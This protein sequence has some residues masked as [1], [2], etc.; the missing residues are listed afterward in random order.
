MTGWEARA[1]DKQCRENFFGDRR[2]G[3]P[4]FIGEVSRMESVLSEAG[5]VECLPKPFLRRRRY[6]ERM[7]LR[8]CG[9][10][11]TLGSYLPHERELC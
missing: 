5:W 10:F 3:E 1:W 11:L 4:Y 8:K 6:V 9:L 7:L 2:S